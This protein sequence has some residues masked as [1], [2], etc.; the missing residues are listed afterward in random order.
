[1]EFLRYTNTPSLTNSAF[2]NVALITFFPPNLGVPRMEASG[3][4]NPANTNAT[5]VA[6]ADIDLYVSTNPALTNL[7]PTVIS[8]AFAGIQGAVSVN[9][10]GNQVVTFANTAVGQVYYIGIKSED[11][12]GAQY[13]FAGVASDVPFNQM[14][15]NGD[16]V[17]TMHVLPAPIPGGS[18]A[19]PQYALIFGVTTL[20][21]PIRDRRPSPKT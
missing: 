20:T 21:T 5:R 3:E 13:G 7:D 14:N 10:T 8:N 16:T 17:V 2:T 15:S 18:A 11:Q 6:G 19:S 1:M 9:R 4:I 12:Q